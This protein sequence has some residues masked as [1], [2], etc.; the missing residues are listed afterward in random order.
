MPD[1]ADL[2]N[3]RLNDY[4]VEG[5][6]QNAQKLKPERHPDFDGSNCVNCGAPLPILR[7]E[8]GRIRCTAC[9]SELEYRRRVAA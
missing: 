5:L 7:L 9:Q 6:T 4:L 2:A 8:M 3:E 1:E